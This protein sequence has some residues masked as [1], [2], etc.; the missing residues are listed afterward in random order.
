M[1]IAR[2]VA[3][4]YD[5]GVTYSAAGEDRLKVSAP[6]GRLSL[7]LQAALREHKADLLCLCSGGVTIYGRGRE[8]G[9]WALERQMPAEVA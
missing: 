6:A 9:E 3:V 1:T 8:P 2:L 4:L 7:E 5:L